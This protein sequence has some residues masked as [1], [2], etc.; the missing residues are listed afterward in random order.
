M[1]ND[2]MA[3]DIAARGPEGTRKLDKISRCMLGPLERIDGDDEHGKQ[4][5]DNDPCGEAETEPE[6]QHGHE[7]R[8]GRHV[9]GID[10]R[11]EQ[12][13][14]LPVDSHPDTE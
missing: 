9:E 7:G 1:R 2:D 5:D 14:N 6:D 8:Y 13:F 10:E 3:D 12:A 11:V 4:V